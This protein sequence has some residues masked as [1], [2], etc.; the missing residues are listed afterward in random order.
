MGVDPALSRTDRPAAGEI[1]ATISR[2][3][4]RVHRDYLG[5]G[6]TKARTSIRDNT[7]VV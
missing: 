2:A 1:S 7:V 3:I 6:P 5:R 4:V